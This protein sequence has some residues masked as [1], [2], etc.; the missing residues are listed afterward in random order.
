MDLQP[1]YV[2][3]VENIKRQGIQKRTGN[4]RERRTIKEQGRLRCARLMLF[5]DIHS[6]G[7]LDFYPAKKRYACATFA[8][9]IR[10]VVRRTR[11]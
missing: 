8:H 11:H 7:V 3:Y 9:K 1:G 4:L 5:S 2:L 10:T 6:N